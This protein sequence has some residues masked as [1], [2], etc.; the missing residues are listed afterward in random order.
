MQ[1]LVWYSGKALSSIS[2][3]ASLLA[4]IWRAL[5]QPRH[6]DRR[7]SDTAHL[8]VGAAEGVEDHGDV[9]GGEAGQERLA[10][11]QPGVARLGRLVAGGR[12]RGRRRLRRRR[13]GALGPLGGMPCRMP[14]VLSVSSSIGLV[15]VHT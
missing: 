4:G 12:R 5:C 8:R 13:L 10:G 1:G 15:S 7:L 9:G 3:R 2:M 14:R 6:A 11:G